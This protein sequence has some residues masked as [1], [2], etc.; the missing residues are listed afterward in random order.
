[1][2]DE[3]TLAQVPIVNG[4]KIM[5]IGTPQAVVD[6]IFINNDKK[7]NDLNKIIK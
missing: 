2:K 1:M 4:T 3:A 5:L 6:S 7:N